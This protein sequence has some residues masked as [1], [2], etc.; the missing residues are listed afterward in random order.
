MFTAELTKRHRIV[1]RIKCRVDCIECRVPDGD[2]QLSIDPDDW[3]VRSDGLSLAITGFTTQSTDK[4][5]VNIYGNFAGCDNLR[6][7]YKGQEAEV[8]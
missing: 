3:G 7:L 2:T 8:T 1:N 4:V 6:V 5:R